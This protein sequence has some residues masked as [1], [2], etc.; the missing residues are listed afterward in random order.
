[1]PAFGTSYLWPRCLTKGWA[2]C[3]RNKF[4]SLPTTRAQTRLLIS[5]FCIFNPLVCFDVWV[6][7]CQPLSQPACLPAR[8]PTCLHTRHPSKQPACLPSSDTPDRTGPWGIPAGEPLQLPEEP[9]WPNTESH[10]TIRNSC[11]GATSAAKTTDMRHQNFSPH[12]GGKLISIE[13]HEISTSKCAR[14]TV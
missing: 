10:Q 1:M 7:V 8:Q 9:T 4:P 3:I 6:F 14:P 2:A 12:A 5:F 13:E 11:V